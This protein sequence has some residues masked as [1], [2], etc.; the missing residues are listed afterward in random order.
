MPV[1][2]IPVE[3]LGALLGRRLDP[4]ELLRHLGHLGCDVEGYTELERVRC[5]NCGA[6]HER[7][8]S[9]EIP[10]TCETCGA[11]LRGNC[12]PLA[13]LEV[14]RMELLAVRPD[15]F[16]PGG[17]ARALRGYLG[18]ETGRPDYAVGPPAACLTVDPAVREPRSYRPWI[19]AAV[20]ENV[21][22]DPDALKIVMKLQEN[23]HWAIGRNRKH[24]SIGVYDFDTVEPELVYTVG[25]PQKR[26]FVPLGSPSTDERHAMTLR[27]ILERHPKGIAFAG[28]LA[29][30]ARYPLLTDKT[31]RVLSMPPIINSEETKV[32]AASRRLVIDVTGL[33]ER[34]VQR[35]LNI[36]ASSLCENLPGVQLRAVEIRGP[37]EARRVTPDF[38][39][40]AIT[41]STARAAKALGVDL[42]PERAAELLRRMRHA[43]TVQGETLAVEVPAYRNDILHE[44]D[45]VEDLGIA[46]GYHN[47]VPSLVP[48]FTVGGPRAIE[49]V[50]ERAR[51]LLCGLG[52][53]EVMTLLLTSDDVHDGGLGRAPA[54]DAVRVANPVSSEATMLRTSLLPGI[55]ETFRR[56]VT[57]PLPQ[58]V[59]E[60]GEV[61][62]LDPRAETGAR[63]VRHLACGLTSARAGFEEVKAIAEAI[64][65]EFGRPWRLEALEVSPFLAGR[66]AQAVLEP[67]GPAV[68]F[69]EV[70][71]EVLE[72]FGLQNPTVLLEGDLET[73]SGLA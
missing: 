57:H 67:G 34:T 73:L 16:D 46:Y 65:R 2:G 44:I 14:I 15:M 11:E 27:E 18:I 13:P 24:A 53:L 33:A 37:E 70:H 29:D 66:V 31:G 51:A 12:E 72:R 52:F 21:T 64:L 71:P 4:S 61:T 50:A 42:D 54:T 38:T 49:N 10:P 39:S 41:V 9:E 63:D 17:L 48:T 28:L 22:L 62:R 56:N 7:T 5:R 60:V 69:G 6:I 8:A 19:A 59:F 68:T 32:T 45:L 55:L 23:L 26:R 47:I 25:D 35:T 30:H 3:R 1:V 36:L 43:V 40:Q 58:Q 20:L